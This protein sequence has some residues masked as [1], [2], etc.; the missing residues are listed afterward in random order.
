MS[1][2]I[3]CKACNNE[4]SK[5]AKICPKCGHK[6][7]K[8]IYKR[9]WFWLLILF[10]I[11]VIGGASSNSK[12]DDSKKEDKVETTTQQVAENNTTTDTTKKEEVKEDPIKDAK[13][14][15]GTYK[16]G[17][18]LPTGEYLFISK[19]MG[20]VECTSD[21]SGALESIV[22]ND[23]VKGHTF[24]TVND[25]EYLKIQGGEMYPVAQ[26]PSIIPGDGTYKDGMYRV[27]VDMPQGEYKVVLKNSTLGYYEVS[28]DSRHVLGSIVTN[29][30]V[31]ADGYLTVQ[32]GQYLKLQGVEIKT[33]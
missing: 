31:Q 19:S 23:N 7:K 29:E 24:L 5:G 8:P 22:F 18:D 9:V 26:A 30:N 15:A 17:T 32:N 14:K 13:I 1:K 25:G 28:T 20:Y 11:G 16:V 12:S 6:N 2:M 4:I 3:L 27:G 21:S 33:K 10:V